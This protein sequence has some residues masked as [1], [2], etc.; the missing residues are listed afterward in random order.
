MAKDKKDKRPMELQI[1]RE[2][3]VNPVERIIK[4]KRKQNESKKFNLNKYIKESF[5]N[6]V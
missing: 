2:W 3:T 6:E 1:R 5:I 4:D